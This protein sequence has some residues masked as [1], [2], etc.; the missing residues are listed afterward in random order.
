MMLAGFVGAAAYG[1]GHTDVVW[2]RTGTNGPRLIQEGAVY[3]RIIRLR[4][5]ALLCGYERDGRCW[6][7]RSEDE[8]RTWGQELL[9]AQSSVGG[10]ANPEVLSLADGRILLCINERPTDR[11]SPFRILTRFSRDEGKTWTDGS[12]IYTADS[13]PRN[14]CWEPCARHLP[15]GEI[16][17]FFAN[18]SPYRHSDEQEISVVRS[19]DGARSWSATETA[20]FRKGHRDGMPV[21]LLLPDGTLL[22]AIEDNGNGPLQP[23]VIRYTKSDLSAFTAVGGESDQRIFPVRPPLAKDR[24]AGAPYL[25]LLKDG[26]VLLSSQSDE[27]G[28]NQRMVVYTG[29]PPYRTFS[30]RSEPFLLPTQTAGNWNSLFVLNSDTVFALSSTAIGGRFGLWMATGHLVSRP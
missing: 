24:Y 15:N 21:P 13:D 18:E 9:A 27:N 7:K 19:R 4:S 11:R 16:L 10:A 2:E 22:M 26:T 14:G 28:H 25:C 6:V 8:G 5:G 17:L 23:A 3:G 12:V 30:N 1:Q 20:A 29:T